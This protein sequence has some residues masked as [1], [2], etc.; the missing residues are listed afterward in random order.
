MTSSEGAIH[1]SRLEPRRSCSLREYVY[2]IRSSLSCVHRL[3]RLRELCVRRVPGVSVCARRGR[4]RSSSSFR[5]CVLV[6]HSPAR[7]S[8]LDSARLR[9]CA[10]VGYWRALSSVVCDPCD[11]VSFIASVTGSGRFFSELTYFISRGPSHTKQ[12]KTNDRRNRSFLWC[13][14]ELSI[15]ALTR[16]RCARPCC[17]A[18]R[19]ASTRRSCSSPPPP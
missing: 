11:G 5:S 6:L 10:K 17:A 15:A 7:G 3:R 16:R 19:A 9:V 1:L 14:R 12:T 2:G 4:R 13:E 18:S 8:S